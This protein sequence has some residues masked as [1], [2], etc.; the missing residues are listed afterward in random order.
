MNWFRKDEAG[1][2]VWPGFSE[3][4]RVLK[5]MIERIEGK[6]DAVETPVGYVPTADALDVTGLDLSVEALQVALNVDADEWKA[7]LPLIEEWFA[8][9]GDTVPAELKVELDHLKA[10]LG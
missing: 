6:A 10:R 2:F 5:W 3:N 4:G 8:K 9:L 1:K 7:E